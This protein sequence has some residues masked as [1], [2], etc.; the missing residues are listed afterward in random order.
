MLPLVGDLAPVNRR[1]TA[2]SIVTSGLIAG[3]LV[4]R[5]LSGIVANYIHWRY[6]Y[7]IAFAMQ[8]LIVVLLYFY[9]PDYPSTNPGVSLFRKY[10]VIL[11][12]IIKMTLKHPVLMQACL[13]GFFTASTFTSF[14]TTLTFL[15]AGPP[16]FYSSLKI[17]LFA[18]IS[19]GSMTWGPIFA[20]TFMDK[21]IPQLSVLIGQLITLTGIIVGTYTGKFTAAGPAIQAAL[22]DIGLQTS[23]IG[24]RTAI[25]AVEPKARN[26]VN[27]AYMVS[28]FCGQLMGTAVGNHLYARG[29]WI[30]SGSAS[31][32]FAAAALLFGLIR[33]PHTTGWIGWSGGFNM[34]KSQPPKPS[35]TIADEERAEISE[36]PKTETRV[37]EGQAGTLGQD[38]EKQEAGSES[39]RTLGSA[40]SGEQN[41]ADDVKKM[42]AHT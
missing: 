8:Y 13:I 30:S 32:G 5:L 36:K 37:P 19:L 20:R 22:I 7:W 29:G 26:R 2:I 4:A 23:Q 11:L 35:T 21:H 41:H 10:P 12:D 42:S 3:M 14:W 31:V 18:L 6:I 27:T 33:G 25:Y 34:N 17:G 28:V 9:M 15:L 38:P 1:A 16:Y 40:Q 24:N 39:V